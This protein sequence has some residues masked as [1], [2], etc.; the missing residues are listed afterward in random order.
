M[1][2]GTRARVLASVP[3]PVPEP[4]PKRKRGR[5][6]K[7]VRAQRDG[8]PSVTP[9]LKSVI[10]AHRPNGVPETDVQR[11][12]KELNELKAKFATIDATATTSK[13]NRAGSVIEMMED[14]SRHKGNFRN[15]IYGAN[16]F[17]RLR[18][19]PLV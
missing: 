9:V 2:T 5:P 16:V 4:E 17:Q 12:Q 19:K 13:N 11:L 7:A 6:P 14:D 10:T 8:S 3:D 1:P 18:A 15:D